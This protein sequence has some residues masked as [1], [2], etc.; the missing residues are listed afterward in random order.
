MESGAVPDRAR[1]F[2]TLMAQF[3]LIRGLLI[4][5]AGHHGVA[6]SSQHVVA[7]VQTAAKTPSSTIW[8]F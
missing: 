2:A 8:S 3:A 1:E 4:G 6:F 5:V 7:T